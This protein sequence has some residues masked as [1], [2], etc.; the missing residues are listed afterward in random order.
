MIADRIG[1]NRAVIWLPRWLAQGL[2]FGP[3]LGTAALVAWL[4]LNGPEGPARTTWAILLSQA[5]I[6]LT[7]FTGLVIAGR[8]A[9]RGPRNSF[10]LWIQSVG[11]RKIAYFGLP[12][13]I[14]QRGL[15]A[16]Q[17]GSHHQV[18]RPRHGD[19]VKM[20]GGAAQPLGSLRFDIPV[21]L[22]DHGAQLLQPR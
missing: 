16:G 5:A 20:Y 15:A 1:P 8:V 19:A 21:L 10:D 3:A 17:N 12:C 6:F 11:G 14:H 18:F 22:M 4:A 9:K 13:R 2:A 7:W